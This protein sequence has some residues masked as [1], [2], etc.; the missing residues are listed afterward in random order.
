MAIRWTPSLAVGI[1][2]I[3]RQHKTLFQKVNDLIE[4]CNR[5]QGKDTVAQTI[6]FL[7]EYVVIHFRDE[8]KLMQKH[9]FPGYVNHKGLHDGFI[10][11]FHELNDQLEKE[12]PGLS[13]VLKTNRMVV[14]WLVRHIS[15]KD[16]EFGEFLRGEG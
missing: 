4:A 10:K 16:K 1:D 13:L 7:G 12:G 8:E 3:D 9:N 2:E 14:D 15:K 6:A 5:G 11:G